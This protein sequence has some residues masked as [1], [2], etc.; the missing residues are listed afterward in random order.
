MAKQEVSSDTMNQDTRIKE[1]TEENELLFEQLHVV[2]EELEKYYHKLKEYE[3]QKGTAVASSPLSLAFLDPKLS[4]TLADNQRLCAL[5][6]QQKFALRVETQNSLSARLG[7]MLINGV[8]STRG[9]F[10]LPGKL[11]KMWKALE[12]TTPPS[13]L[14]GKSFQAVIDAYSADGADAV[15]KKLDSV[16][17]APTMRANAYTALARHLMI[18][19]VQT[20]AEFAHRAY[21]TDPRPYRLKW[22]AFR[23]H[24]AND[25]VTAEAMLDMLPA[26]IPMSESEERQVAR[27]RRESKQLLKN[28]AQKDASVQALKDAE[29]KN[30]IQLSK[31]VEEH[32]REVDQLRQEQEELKKLANTRQ[33]DLK[34]LKG[35]LAAQ[36]KLAVSQSAEAEA[37]K[38]AQKESQALANGYKSEAESLQARLIEQEALAKSQQQEVNTLLER[39]AE[40][41]KQSELWLEERLSFETVQAELQVLSSSYKS[42][43]EALQTR[44]IEQEALASSRQQEVDTLL[45]WLAEQ[46]KQS[47]KWREENVSLMAAHDALQGLTDDSKAE[48]AA[49]QVCLAEQEAQVESQRAEVDALKAAQGEFQLLANGYKSEVEILQARLAQQEAAQERQSEEWQ[50]EIV[51]LKAAQ[52]KSQASADSY[53]TE[54]V[55]LQVRLAEQEALANERRIEVDRLN[56]RLDEMHKVYQEEVRLSTSQQKDVISNIATHNASLASSFEKQVIELERVRESVKQTCRNE[57]DNALQQVAIYNGL[58]SYFESGKLPEINRW[59]QGWPANQEIIL[60]FVEFMN[61]NNNYLAT[62]VDKMNASVN[63]ILK[64]LN[65]ELQHVNTNNKEIISTI[66]S[67]KDT[68]NSG[69]EKHNADLKHVHNSIKKYFNSEIDNSLRQLASYSGLNAYFESGKLP[70]VTLWKRGWPA[71]PD[72]ILWLVELID[73]NDYDLILEFGS[74]ITT[75]YTAKALAAREK[76]DGT[77]KKASAVTFEHL[78]QF[79]LQTRGIL[80]HAGVDGYVNLIHAPLQEYVAPDG[81]VYQYYSCQESLSLLSQHYKTANSRILVIVDGPPGVTCKNARYPAFPLVMK[82]FASAHIDFLLDDYI[83]DDEKEIATMWQN[84]C[85]TAGIEHA[86]VEKQLEKEALL[87][88]IAP[89]HAES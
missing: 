39:L 56:S 65:K 12:R 15:E 63:E 44:L 35:R 50:N 47:K 71:S 20:A 54:A 59:K 29:N 69:F 84:A 49:L 77:E 53:R 67:Y 43:T 24:D 28:N 32:R 21:E 23:M 75:L 82:Y 31:Q 66:E 51:S 64:L 2:Q 18:I 62:G 38:V 4:E 68:I 14:G 10:A 11:R 40:H 60:G 45:D 3:Q 88:R 37:L 8:G 83:R 76:K 81:A 58:S 89:P 22:L 79:F 46:E 42:E 73:R 74:G 33:A 78:E 72:F 48:V 80:S 27:I 70:E 1:L 52:V 6:A 25:A 7:D 9:I 26:D 55:A 36:E 13:E 16:F 86:I 87:L 19:D 85:A 5:V 61:R 41:Q 57:L 17:I 34:A 30:I